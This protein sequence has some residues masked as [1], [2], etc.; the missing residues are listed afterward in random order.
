M[1]GRR[2]SKLRALVAALGLMLSVAGRAQDNAVPSGLANPS[3]PPQTNFP[4]APA[5]PRTLSPVIWTEDPTVV[6]RFNVDGPRVRQM[7]DNALLKLTSSSDLGTAWTRLGITPQ[8][9]VGIKIT[10]MGGPLLSTHRALVQA[11]CD[12]LQA[13]GVPPSQII[14]WD[15]D[16][17]NM[18]SAGYAP[19]AAT[20]TH[21]GI[22]SIF[23]D[24]GYD[25]DAVYKSDVLGT[26][27]WGDS[28]FIRHDDD[29]LTAASQ[30]VKN[31]GFGDNGTS[32]AATAAE[33]T[34][35]SGSTAPQ[36]SNRSHFARIVTTLCTKIIN[37]PVL[38]DNS[39]IG[40]NGCLGSLALACVDNNRRFQGDPTY[41]DPAIDEILSNDLL[42]RKVVIH[43]LDALI[44]QYAGGPHFEPVFTKSIGAIYVSRDPVA[45]DALVL[46]RMDEW[47]AAD[48]QGRIDPIGKTAAHIHTA[49][50]DNLGTDDPAR[51]QL[52]RLP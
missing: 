7:V 36:T 28:E 25:P 18:R 50:T 39:Y 40:I 22:T 35:T 21:V 33:D 31:K 34:L 37:V 27:I 15:K 12:G 2:T 44:S 30:A 49:A 43:I 3:P 6:Q 14:I 52:L 9:V 24:T 16:A 47:R 46:K 13:A 48:K 19:V 51:I 42:R 8:D 26:L 4:A 32:A 23:P 45:I 10:T 5:P 41:G 17:T 11:I 1:N 38:T 29:L 20:D